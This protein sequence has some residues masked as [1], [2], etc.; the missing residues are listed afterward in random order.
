M[1]AWFTGAIPHG[2]IT[3]LFFYSLGVFTAIARTTSQDTAEA[4][5]GRGHV[6]LAM[7]YGLSIWMWFRGP[8]TAHASLFLAALLLGYLPASPTFRD[9]FRR[10]ENADSAAPSSVKWWFLLA[11]LFIIFASAAQLWLRAVR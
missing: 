2:N 1:I 11:S 3:L 6:D 7:L 5:P 8:L 9:L 4:G 10:P